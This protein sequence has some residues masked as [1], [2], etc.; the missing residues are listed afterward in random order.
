LAFES[1]L[2][3]AALASTLLDAAVCSA[4]KDFERALAHSQQ[5]G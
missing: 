4:K 1:A 3:F 2:A 5:F